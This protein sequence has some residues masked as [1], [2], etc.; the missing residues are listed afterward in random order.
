MDKY[1]IVRI[2]ICDISKKYLS[3]FNWSIDITWNNIMNETASKLM[4]DYPFDQDIRMIFNSICFYLQREISA[5]IASKL[6][7]ENLK[8]IIKQIEIDNKKIFDDWFL[9]EIKTKKMNGFW[10]SPIENRL[11]ELLKEKDR[12]M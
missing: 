11:D 2:A 7:N 5:Y 8:K 4:L 12:I 9:N 10:I 6:D 1:E 3:S